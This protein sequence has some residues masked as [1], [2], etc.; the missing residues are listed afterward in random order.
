MTNINSKTFSRIAVIQVLHQSSYPAMSGA[1]E[2]E[3]K[4]ETL[5]Q[6]PDLSEILD[7]RENKAKIK[8]NKNLFNDLCTYAKS[9]IDEI[10]DYIIKNLS[11]DSPHKNLSQNLKAILRCAIAEILSFPETPT[12]VIL[13]EYTNIASEMIGQNE[14]GFVN[15]ILD[16]ICKEVRK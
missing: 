11:S 13:N 3:K 15:W 6:S 16:T 8:L 9:H 10:D 2:I 7:L 1:R 5:Y 12:L 14:V 4:I